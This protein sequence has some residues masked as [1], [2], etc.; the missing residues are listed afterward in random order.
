M[1]YYLFEV[2]YGSKDGSSGKYG[3]VGVNATSGKEAV[4]LALKKITPDDYLVR[5]PRTSF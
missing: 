4:K 2:R 5:T 1:K 3:L